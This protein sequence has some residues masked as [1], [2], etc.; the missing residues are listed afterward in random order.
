MSDR[1]DGEVEPAGGGIHGQRAVDPGPGGAPSARARPGYLGFV[2]HEVRNPLSSALW[3][4]ELL[5]RISP[6]ERGGARG[7]KLAETCRRALSRLR[8]LVEDHLLSE[9][10]D[11]ADLPVR[12]EAV[13]L[14]ELVAAAQRRAGVAV[15]EAQIAPE[16]AAEA[17]R[18]LAERALEGILAAAGRDGTAVSLEA[19]RLGARVALRVRGAAAMPG[20]LEDPARG[21]TPLHRARPLALS[22]ARRAAAAAGGRL[23]LD[24]GAYLLDFPAA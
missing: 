16:L 20:S 10:L 21:S 13:G 6:Q 7:Q 3:S 19:R 8:H 5:A 2:A 18:A 22:M 1:V 11:A 9:R 17:D 23:A 14:D 4:A 15:A 24:Q 12:T